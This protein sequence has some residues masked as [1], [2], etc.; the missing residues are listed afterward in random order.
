ME[1]KYRVFDDGRTLGY[2]GLTCPVCVKDELIGCNNPV[3]FRYGKVGD[4]EI[5]YDDKLEWA[6]P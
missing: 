2:L 5:I 1:P 6:L 3:L 4:F